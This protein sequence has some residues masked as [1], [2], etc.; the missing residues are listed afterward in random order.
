MENVSLIALSRAATLER[1][2]AIVA[3]NVA[4]VS[5]TGFQSESP[6]FTEYLMKPSKDEQYSMVQDQ[7]TLRN[8]AP[9][10]V[11]QT[12]NPL[13]LALEGNGYFEVDTLDGPRYTRAGNFTMNPDREL[14]T[15]SGLPIR[16]ETGNKITIPANTSEIT[17]NTDGSIFTEKGPVGKIGLFSFKNEQKLKP[18]GNSLL[19]ADSKPTVSEETTV[20]Q[21]YLEQS[22][23]QSVVEMTNMIDISRQYESVQKMLQ[24]ENDRLRNAYSKL[25]KLT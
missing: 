5:T 12:G 4:N 15:L 24:A 18:V 13:D 1:Q 7:G 8:L 10:A 22:N 23:V 17:I 9:G 2:M 14:V 25:S 3:N 21:G 20:R 19:M 6:L 11:T 16:D